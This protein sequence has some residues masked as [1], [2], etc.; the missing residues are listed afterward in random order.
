MKRNLVILL[1]ALSMRAAVA[2]TIAIQ[3]AVE[4]GFTP[5]LNK[6]YLIE[7]SSTL[8]G[9]TGL[10]PSIVGQT[11]RV[12]R[13]FTTDEQQQFFRVSTT[14]VMDLTG[15][16]TPIRAANNVPALGCAVV[17]NNRIVGLGV[18]GVR[19]QGVTEPAT[20]ADHWHHG[21]MT[22]SM[23]AVL[24]AMLVD[25]GKISWNTKL[26]DVFPEHAG[27]RHA[28]WA[29]ATL[30]MLLTNSGGAP[31]DLNP[32]GIWIQL[33][34]HQGTPREQ[35]LFLTQQVTALAP[36]FTPGTAYEYSNAGFSMAGAMLE[37]VTG[38]TWEQLMTERF[39][40]PLGMA[41]GGFGVPATPRHINHPWGHSL[42]GST[43]VPV[44]PGT[45]ADNPPGIGP[46]GTVKCSLIDFGRYI[47]FQLAGMRGEGTLLQPGTFTKLYTPVHADYAMGWIV[48]S[49]S[50]SNGAVYTHSGSNTQWYTNVWIAPGRNWAVVVVTNVGGAPAIAATNA[51]VTAM[52]TKF[53]P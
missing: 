26:A 52:I 45:T 31:G 42:S 30:E 28:G 27:T 5:E 39:F 9:W 41:S 7:G 38:K 14:D 35:R 8:A 32:S 51:A 13:F 4:I 22:K 2:Q 24:A 11:N 50:W 25:E 19:K 53:I 1:L 46:A 12:G 3:P 29:N 43:P 15:D 34:S 10:G 49:R 16:L 21:S 18:V 20:L 37:K 48:T 23:T 33:W 36:R 44:E 40:G 17:M 6:E 47:A